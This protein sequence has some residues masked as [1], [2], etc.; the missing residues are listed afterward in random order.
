VAIRTPE[1]TT[2]AP[3]PSSSLGPISRRRQVRML[4]MYLAL[5][6]F[7]AVLVANS[8]AVG[9]QAFGAGLWFPG[10]GFLALGGWWMLPGGLSAIAFLSALAAWFKGGATLLPPLV[11]LL[12]AATA[13]WAAG[14]PL[15]GYGVAAAGA[16]PVA[17]GL[18]A[19]VLQRRCTREVRRRRAE[20]ADYLPAQLAVVRAA[21]PQ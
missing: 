17:A 8:R 10:S 13:A 19:A 20:R 14:E 5:A 15:P 2:P 16:M 12:S 9:A 4:A 1:A 3:G 6:A 18:L 7:G 21:R 11:W